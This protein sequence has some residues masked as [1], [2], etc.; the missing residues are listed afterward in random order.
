MA[1]ATR[2]RTDPLSELEAREEKA[3]KARAEANAAGAG[4]EGK[5]QMIAAL[6]EEKR[7][8]YQEDPS[9]FDH[10]GNPLK[11]SSPA[12]KIATELGKLDFGDALARYEH[13]KQ[14]AESAEQSC[15]DFCIAH[16]AELLEAVEPQA[17]A[18][19]AEVER[20][21]QALHAAAIKYLALA[22]R[23]DGW[24]GAAAQRDTDL[25]HIRI[26]AVDRGSEL[27]RATEPLTASVPLPTEGAR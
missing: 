16:Y 7:R 13:A 4:A 21:G 9:S 6:E 2:Q 14:I 11:A 22:Q 24:R 20:C 19:A 23:I 15:R 1:T 25:R 10:R 3:E 8:L 17:E 27:L 5:R 26:G 12:G 18:A